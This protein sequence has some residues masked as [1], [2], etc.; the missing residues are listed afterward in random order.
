MLIQ[1]KAADNRIIQEQ[2]NQK[3]K[4]LAYITLSEIPIILLFIMFL[5]KS[6]IWNY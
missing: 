4:N 1:V 6:V 5:A 2:L 3:V